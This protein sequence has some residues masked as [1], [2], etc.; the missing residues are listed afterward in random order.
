MENNRAF[1]AVLL[2]LMI[3][4]AYQ[5]W[6]MPRPGKQPATTSAVTEKTAGN[7]KAQAKT[8]AAPAPAAAPAAMPASAPAAD[9][10]P[11]REIHVDTSLYTA[12]V[13][14]RGGGIKSFKL[15]K[16]RETI[17]KDSPLKELIFTS[18][19]AE[20]P[21][22]FA[23]GNG[24]SEPPPLFHAGTASLATTPGGSATLTMT[25][26]PVAGITITRTM[27]FHDDSYLI[28]VDYT[29]HNT[30]SQAYEGAPF[31]RL[32]NRPFSPNAGKQSFLFVGPAYFDAEGLQEIKPADLIKKGPQRHSGQV[33]WVAYE[34]SYFLCAA[35]PEAP[36]PVTVK[37]SAA[38]GEDEV[39]TVTSDIIGNKEMI[40]P[41]AT[42]SY[43][44]AAYLGPKKLS[45]LK[46][47]NHDLAKVVNFGWF[48]AIAKPTLYLLNFLY[49]YLHNYG[50]AIILVTVLFKLLFWP[51][52]HKGMKS[53][54]NMQ[55]IQPKMAKL[56]EKY[57]D[58]KDRLNRE[59][60]QLYKTYKVNPLGGCLP[61]VLQIPVFFALYRVLLQ[62]IELRH[63]PFMLW[64]NDLSAPDRLYI[65]F[66]IPFLGG[67]PV[68]TLLMGLSMFLQQKMT[69]S[70]ADPSQAKV[71]M[72]LPVIFTFM[73]L[74][75]ASGL[76][77]YW[78]VNNLLSI[79]QQYV[80]NRSVEE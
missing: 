39:A 41:G 18:R 54:K 40:R 42:L 14:E 43:R 1:A 34:D 80:I 79:G 68:L 62:T 75:F 59:M 19:P 38:A 24:M 36:G 55:K 15:K 35:L 76:V 74:N 27:V 30:T 7:D 44:Y 46:Q 45:I 65:G 63:A 31:L 37:L 51:I 25:A 52:S 29:V 26:E 53:M 69:P 13:T 11:A 64:I 8:S 9:L 48:D 78:F 47:V 23:W 32:V 73:F 50:V 4:L 70:P 10:P 21:L 72:F 5:Y 3:L 71:M 6:F 20:Y 66:H 58:D 12:V 49:G 56:R 22:T 57:K 77:L 61:M 16:Y 67:I 33:K 2:S 28:D 17:A 60:I